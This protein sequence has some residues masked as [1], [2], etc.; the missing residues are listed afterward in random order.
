[1]YSPTFPYK[2]PQAIITSD[3][4]VLHAKN[5]AIFLFG[6]QTVSL[7]S[8]GT[9]NIDSINKVT[10]NSPVIELG[11]KASLSTNGE[12]AILGDTLVTQLIHFLNNLKIFTQA[13]DKIDPDNP[14]S[15]SIIKTAGDALTKAIPNTINGL[16]NTV[17]S[18]TVFIQKNNI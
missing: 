16:E 7:S 8:K 18:Q 3:R 6:S 10:I 9:V 5:D 2:G 14:K 15:I 17:R 4:I 1:M 12:K 11:N 13:L